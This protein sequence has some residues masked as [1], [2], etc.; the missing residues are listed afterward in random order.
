MLDNTLINNNFDKEKLIED[1]KNYNSLLNT[2]IPLDTMDI[3]SMIDKIIDKRPSFIDMFSNNWDL[4]SYTEKFYTNS[5]LL[6]NYKDKV[7]IWKLLNIINSFIWDDYKNLTVSDIPSIINTWD[8]FWILSHP[9]FLWWNMVYWNYLENIWENKP[10]ISFAWENISMN[11][12]S[13]PRWIILNWNKKISFVS[14]KNKHYNFSDSSLKFKPVNDIEKI[15]D[16]DNKETNKIREI[17]IEEFSKSEK[18]IKNTIFNINNKIWNIIYWKD[19]LQVPVNTI[20]TKYILENYE[21]FTDLFIENKSNVIS[22]FKDKYW[23]YIEKDWITNGTTIW[24]YVSENQ[25]HKSAILLDDWW[26]YYKSEDLVTYIDDDDIFNEIKEWNIQLSLSSVYIILID[27]WLLP[28]WWFNQVDYIKN[29]FEFYQSSTWKNMKNHISFISMFLW[30]NFWEI[31]VVDLINWK[32]KL[33]GFW[34]FKIN[35]MIDI[36]FISKIV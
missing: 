9:M 23:W 27:M 16:I 22:F 20:I 30:F 6:D 31:N 32:K 10:I 21:I 2:N 7:K 5:E 28:L 15:F 13:Y 8:H 26:Y 1:Y 11:N 17:V 24:F 18:S 35:S 12:Q 33:D 25:K 14:D 34:K 36:D 29:Y 4:D 3:S 19:F